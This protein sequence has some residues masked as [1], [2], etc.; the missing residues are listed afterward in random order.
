MG[1]VASEAGGLVASAGGEWICWRRVYD[2]LEFWCCM[3]EVCKGWSF[4]CFA[5]DFVI[6]VTRFVFLCTSCTLE[7][8]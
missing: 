2:G 3:D 5:E 6:G 4:L 7:N 8:R 1:L